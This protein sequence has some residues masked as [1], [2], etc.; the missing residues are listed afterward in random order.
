MYAEKW[1]KYPNYG[2]LIYLVVVKPKSPNVCSIIISQH[3]DY[4]A[5]HE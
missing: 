3:C 5:I 4:M 2:S 1:W